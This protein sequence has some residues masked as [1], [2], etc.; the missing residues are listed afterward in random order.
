[1]KEADLQ[2]VAHFDVAGVNA[3]QITYRLVIS[4]PAFPRPW[5]GSNSVILTEG[6]V[7][8]SRKLWI[9]AIGS[10]DTERSPNTP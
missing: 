9:S 7:F 10:P 1:M 2:A 3:V 5:M 8:G 6:E 4:A